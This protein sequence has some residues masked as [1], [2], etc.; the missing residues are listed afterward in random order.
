MET[1]G[2]FYINGE[3]VDLP[4][5]AIPSFGATGIQVNAIFGDENV[6]ANITPLEFNFVGTAART[7]KNYFNS[8]DGFVKLP[9]SAEV[10][11]DA[12]QLDLI[13]GYLD[14]T[15]G[16]EVVSDVQI[17]VKAK[18]NESTLSLEQ[19]VSGVSFDLLFIKGKIQQSDSEEIEYVVEKPINVVEL[20]VT[21]ISLYLMIKELTEF[22]KETSKDVANVLGLSSTGVTGTI[23]ATVYQ[24][25]IIAVR[26]AYNTIMIK[27]I[28]DM[29]TDVITKFISPLYVT[30]GFTY[31]RILEIGFDYLGYDFD[32]NISELDFYTYTPSINGESNPFGIPKANDYGYLFG[33]LVNL[34]RKQFRAKIGVMNGTVYLYPAKDD[35]WIKN[36]QY[37]MES[38]L[39]EGVY[40]ENYNLD[41]L[42]AAR[43][44]EYSL[45]SNDLWTLENYE[46][47]NYVIDTDNYPEIEASES[48]LEGF[49]RTNFN[50]ALGNVKDGLNPL[51][52]SLNVLAKTA[53]VILGIFGS[54]KKLSNLIQKRVGVLKISE[55]TTTIPKCIYL[56]GGRIPLNH[57]EL[58]SAK[59][60]WDSYINYDS[61]IENDFKR[62]R[63]KYTGVRIPFGL[64]NYKKV[65]NNSY[66]YLSDG[67][68]GKI[69]S[70]KWDFNKDEA[71]VDFW[72]E[73]VY[74]KKLKEIKYENR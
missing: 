8:G 17:K 62:Q 68:T 45:D 64:S 67:R 12:G 18:F 57:R 3:S 34:I 2:R 60:N 61:F 19:R 49:E 33:D 74:T 72:I 21:S 23:G 48:L 7:V 41:E 35:F 47:T 28:I 55:T 30:R 4:L 54:G 22:T 71:I 31:R 59:A 70:L 46:G 6:Q 29:V 5:E 58:L 24:I 52:Q 38:V 16:Y 50:V 66:F 27:A 14:L 53:G 63:I 11:G 26:A 56:K 9:F 42:V 65:V 15:D 10:I 20:V 36:S 73:H 44:I 32:S 1:T 43:I 51:E 37:T 69:T 40:G 39:L 25:A 13:D